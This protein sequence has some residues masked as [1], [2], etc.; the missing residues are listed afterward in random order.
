MQPQ[1]SVKNLFQ[2][3]TNDLKNSFISKWLTVDSNF[4]FEIAIFFIS[5][6]PSFRNNPLWVL[7]S[8]LKNQNC[9]FRNSNSLH[10]KLVFCEFKTP[11]STFT[12]DFKINL[13]SNSL[14]IYLKLQFQD[15][16]LE[17]ERIIILKSPINSLQKC[18]L[19]LRFQI[20]KQRN[21]EFI[22]YTFSPLS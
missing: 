2:D 5:N 17:F 14:S 21:F 13:N 11:I 1:Y 4:Y 20:Q 6:L 22:H 16:N 8:I 9:S 7:K 19:H 15:K 3:S 18:H 10:F 12:S